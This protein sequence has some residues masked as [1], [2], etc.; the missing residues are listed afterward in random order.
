MTNK[1][2]FLINNVG[3]HKEDLSLM[4]QM[5]LEVIVNELNIS[6]EWLLLALSKDKLENW[7]KWGFN[8]FK[9]P[10][11]KN[12]V[13]KLLVA[14]GNVKEEQVKNEIKKSSKGKKIWCAPETFKKVY[15][16]VKA[17]GIYTEKEAIEKG[18]STCWIWNSMLK[19]EAR[20]RLEIVFASTNNW[21]E[22]DEDEWV[23]IVAGC[24][25]FRPY[26]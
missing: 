6:K 1:E 4:R 11:F 15:E 3:F 19:E 5:E 24:V 12:E 25:P 13:D 20:Q 18:I 10:E 14:F 16:G 9:K 26:Y 22:V 17:T 7:E 21:Q 8:L 2:K 23:V